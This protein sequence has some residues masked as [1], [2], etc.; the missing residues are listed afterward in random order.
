MWGYILALPFGK[1]N[2]EAGVGVVVRQTFVPLMET[3]PRHIN[4]FQHNVR[5]KHASL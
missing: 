3:E 4:E 5:Q 2:Q 1:E